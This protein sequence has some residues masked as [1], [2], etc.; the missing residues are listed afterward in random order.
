MVH[1]PNGIGETRN[2]TQ[3][4]STKPVGIGGSKCP[5]I[6]ASTQHFAVGQ[7]SQRQLD[8][9][10]GN[11][12]FRIFLYITLGLMVSCYVA[13]VPL[14]SNIDDVWRR[15]KHGWERSDTWGAVANGS[16]PVP[17]LRFATLPRRC[18]PATFALS[19][20]LLAI[21]ILTCRESKTRTS[22]SHL[23]LPSVAAARD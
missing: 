14:A 4:L 12:H 8:G 20:A 1:Q 11:E 15:T 18:W 22:A 9:Q 19:E 2:D 7:E 13:A 21:W 16:H 3:L 17:P 5:V 6:F 10:P 23:V